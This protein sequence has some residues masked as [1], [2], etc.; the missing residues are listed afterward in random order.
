MAP[1]LGDIAIKDIKVSEAGLLGSNASLLT[2]IYNGSNIALD[3]TPG[4]DD[5]LEVLEVN[6]ATMARHE[7]EETQALH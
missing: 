6:T 4:E 5:W 1:A 7:G 3:L 2:P